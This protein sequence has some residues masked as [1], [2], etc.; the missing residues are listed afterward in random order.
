[1]SLP[2]IRIVDL[3]HNNEP[4][5]LEDLT[6]IGLGSLI[7]ECEQLLDK[8]KDAHREAVDKLDVDG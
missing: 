4:V 1:M 6:D 5:E 7:F 8:L 2:A 3:Q